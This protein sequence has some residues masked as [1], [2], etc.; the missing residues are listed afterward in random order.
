MAPIFDFHCTDC[1]RDFESLIRPREPVECKHCLSRIVI[2]QVS[3]PACYIRGGGSWEG[4]TAPKG[5]DNREPKRQEK[6]RERMTAFH[7]N[8]GKWKR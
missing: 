2:R 6:K 5:F 7:E 8:E 3:A 4:S 1:D